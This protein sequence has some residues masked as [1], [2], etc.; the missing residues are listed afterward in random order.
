MCGE[1]AGREL[2]GLGSG[3]PNAAPPSS[4]SEHLEVGVGFFDGLRIT[5]V[6]EA[7]LLGQHRFDFFDELLAAERDTRTEIRRPTTQKLRHGQQAHPIKNVLDLLARKPR[8]SRPTRGVRLANPRLE[9]QHPI[10]RRHVLP[11][12]SAIRGNVAIS[13]RTCTSRTGTSRTGISGAV[14][15]ELR[16]RTQRRRAI[17]LVQAD[18]AG[19]RLL[20]PAGRGPIAT[21]TGTSPDPPPARP[22]PGSFRDS[23]PSR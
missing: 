22:E 20:D 2:E 11:A 23:R 16:P 17:D 4:S 18:Q 5:V 8:T 9:H 6:L 21:P 14:L 13:R 12:G 15:R 19:L 3:G 1:E 7:E 10:P